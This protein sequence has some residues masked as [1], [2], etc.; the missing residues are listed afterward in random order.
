MEMNYDVGFPLGVDLGSFVSKWAIGN[1]WGPWG[2][3]TKE[4][5][6]ANPGAGF[7]ARPRSP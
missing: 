4:S 5:Q 1:P 3:G 7:P 6:L 2:L